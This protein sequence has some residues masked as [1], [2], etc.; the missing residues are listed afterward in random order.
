MHVAHLCLSCALVVLGDYARSQWKRVTVKAVK[1][2]FH[3]SMKMSCCSPWGG[4]VTHN[5][6]DENV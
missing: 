4:K 1:E 2:L 5:C 6:T 3:F